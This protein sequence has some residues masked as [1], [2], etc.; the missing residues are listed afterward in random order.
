MNKTLEEKFKKL[1]KKV[2]DSKLQCFGYPGNQKNQ[3]S[4]FYETIL[5]YHLDEAFLNNVGDPFN[6]STLFPNALDFEKE[7]IEFFAPLYGFDPNDVWGIVTSS[8][9]DGNNHGI[10]FGAKY[11]ERKTHKKPVVYVSDVAHYSNMRLADLQ[12]LDIVMVP[13]D[14]HGAMIPSEFERLLV[15]NRPALIVYAVGTTFKGGVDNQGAINKILNKYPNVEVY[16]HI[17]AALF[18]GYLPYTEYKDVLNQSIQHF[19]SIAISG[20]KFFGM[21]EPAGLFITSKRIKESQNPYNVA[22]LNG[23]MPM[24]NCS[25]SSLLPLKFYW[26][27]NN[28]GTDGFTMQANYILDLAKWLKGELDKLGWTSYLEPMSNIVY[29]KCPPDEITKKYILAQDY[30]ERLGGKLAHIVVMQHVTKENLEEFISDLRN[31]INK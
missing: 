17:D 15:V 25:R 5:K 3:L 23:N 18:G 7:V 13:S 8:G 27:I 21:D 20:H 4:G 9:T 26:I 1:S 22:Y 24:I 2:E 28:V 29:F 10:Y 30:D 14:V 12:N 11:L 16:R 6:D 19:D 31:Y